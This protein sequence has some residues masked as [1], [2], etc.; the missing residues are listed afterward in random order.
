VQKGTDVVL[1]SKRL[2]D[3]VTTLVENLEGS[4][5][6]GDVA[7]AKKPHV[8]KNLDISNLVLLIDRSFTD[9]VA[10]EL[11]QAGLSDKEAVEDHIRQG[12]EDVPHLKHGLQLVKHLEH[13]L[14]DAQVKQSRKI[15]GT[16]VVPATEVEDVVTVALGEMCEPT[17]AVL[18]STYV[19]GFCVDVATGTSA[20][21]SAAKTLGSSLCSIFSIAVGTH[22]MHQQQKNSAI[23]SKQ[24]P[25]LTK[26]LRNG[27]VWS[28]DRSQL[29]VGDVIPIYNGEMSP[30]DGVVVYSD[31]VSAHAVFLTGE[32]NLLPKRAICDGLPEDTDIREHENVLY[33]GAGPAGG[34]G[35]I[36]YASVCAIG[37]NSYLGNKLVMVRG[38]KSVSAMADKVEQV[39]TTALH[40][41]C[42]RNR[43]LM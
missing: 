39:T 28:V 17:T 16:N 1:T 43:L 25:A 36:G 21:V 33:F 7:L 26:V 6:A 18:L 27:K 24:K 8:M 5:P 32:S 12:S 41:N 30:A 13:G 3:A 2:D 14:T 38:D 34:I 23:L 35:I 15:F 29:V 9:E 42:N 40:F 37:Q 11:L 20:A 22:T 10:A 31:N 4:E 19:L